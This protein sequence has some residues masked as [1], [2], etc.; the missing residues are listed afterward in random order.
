MHPRPK[1]RECEIR[2]EEEEQGFERRAQLLK[3]RVWRSE[4]GLKTL[5]QVQGEALKT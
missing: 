2:R 4:L 5:E 1:G 3:L